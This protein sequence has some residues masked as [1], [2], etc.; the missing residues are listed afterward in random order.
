M[1]FKENSKPIYQQ[2]ADR[3]ADEVMNAVYLS[4]VRIPSVRDYA[5]KM[6]VNA[7]TVMRT[8]EY[9]QTRGIIY[10]KRNIG[11]FISPDAKEHIEQMHRESFFDDEMKY[12]FSRLKGMRVAP[13]RLRQL[14]V[15]SSSGAEYKMH[16]HDKT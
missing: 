1:E 5:A 16:N 4:D 6:Q 7:N 11:Y 8:Y 15:E 2:I 3:I 14:Y 10:N 13:E 9:L 12:Y